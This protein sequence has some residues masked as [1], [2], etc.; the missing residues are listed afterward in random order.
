MCLLAGGYA[1]GNRGLLA[2]ENNRA[3]SQAFARP[4]SARR[5]DRAC[6]CRRRSVS[7]SPYGRRSRCGCRAHGPSAA[8][9]ASPMARW[10][11]RCVVAPIERMPVSASPY[12]PLAAS[13]RAAMR[14]APVERW[15]S[16]VIAHGRRSSVAAVERMAHQ[17]L[18]LWPAGGL[19]SS[20]ERRSRPHAPSLARAAYGPCQGRL[21]GVGAYRLRSLAHAA[22][23]AY[24]PCQRRQPGAGYC[25]P[26]A[27]I[28]PSHSNIRICTLADC[29]T[30]PVQLPLAPALVFAYALMHQANSIFPM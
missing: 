21:A 6:S 30:S 22:R 25:R 14:R 17:R 10:R 1:R 16:S 7:A 23:A 29:A 13:I 27:S 2:G 8:L 18:A 19:R 15:P 28:R 9:R 20:G 24:G 4:P 11:P 12:G 26:S 5:H 3:T